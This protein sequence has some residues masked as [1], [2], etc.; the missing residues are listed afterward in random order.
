MCLLLAN[1]ITN[2][3]KQKDYEY[4]NCGS[5]VFFTLSGVATVYRVKLIKV[6]F[7]TCSKGIFEISNNMYE[8]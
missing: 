6:S 4:N 2:K 8:K 7:D 5:N 1:N 3:W